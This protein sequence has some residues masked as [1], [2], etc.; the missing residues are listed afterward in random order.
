MSSSDNHHVRVQGPLSDR[1]MDQL[2]RDFFQ[3]EVPGVLPTAGA[4]S[5]VL[6]RAVPAVFRP[7]TS[8]RSARLAA[9][10]ALAALVLC[11]LVLN[12]DAERT[13]TMA[14]RA[15]LSGPT[16]AMLVSPQETDQIQLAPQRQPGLVQPDER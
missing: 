4:S 14:A 16:D 8:M 2:L 6:H 1:Q 7:A 15:K 9:G 10:L 13:A 5:P 11:A 3:L 12:H